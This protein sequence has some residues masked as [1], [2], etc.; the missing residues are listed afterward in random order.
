VS[1]TASG[2]VHRVARRLALVG[3]AGELATAADITG[4]PPGEAMAAAL[5]CFRA[6]RDTRVGGEGNAEEAQMLSQVRR[7]LQL[8]GAGRFTWWHRGLD[9]RAPDEGM[10]AGFRLLV[11]PDG[12]PIRKDSE[13]M[14]EYGD[15][16]TTADAEKSTVDYFVFPEVFDAEACDGFEKRAVLQVL[17]AAGHLG[18]DKGRPFDCKPRLP[19][20]GPTRCYRIKASIFE[21]DE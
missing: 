10:R 19:G 4:W 8:N 16:I 12:T 6:W 15:K 20:L 2:Q 1:H 11:S 9:D 17:R 3:V 14:M 7:W 5:A 18:P 13:H 21:G